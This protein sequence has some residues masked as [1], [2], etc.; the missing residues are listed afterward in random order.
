LNEVLA[1]LPK[2]RD[3]DGPISW[4][5]RQM[6]VQVSGASVCEWSQRIC[7]LLKSRCH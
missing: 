3:V 1:F 5:E 7:L 4:Q 6:A 2:L